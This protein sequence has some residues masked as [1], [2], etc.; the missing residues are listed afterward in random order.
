MTIA[1]LFIVGTLSSAQAPAAVPQS[2]EAREAQ[3]AAAVASH[4]PEF[5]LY[6]ELARIYAMTGRRD[7]AEDVLRRALAVH[8]DSGE[9]FAALAGL[10]SE[11]RDPQK[12]LEVADEWMRVE[13]TNPQ[14]LLVLSQAHRALASEKK[15]DPA[16]AASHI[17]RATRAFEEA[18]R[19]K[20]A[21]GS[22]P[23]R[24]IVQAAQSGSSSLAAAFPDAIRVGGAVRMPAK[25]KDVKPVMPQ[26]AIDAR[27]QGVV[28]MEIVVDESGA[29]ADARVLRSIPLLDAA[30]LEAVK[31][32]QFQPTELEGR[33]VPVIVTVTVQF[34]GVP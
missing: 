20:A 27:V 19:L 17:E 24:P 32:W 23:T 3:L 31:Q 26:A 6:R 16:E 33:P 13:P 30:A 18:V 22:T 12:L 1:A 14:P 29:V 9:V 15:A 34:T 25:T 7:Q 8:A 4:T 11:P 2:P 28:I 5:A 21:A 10:H